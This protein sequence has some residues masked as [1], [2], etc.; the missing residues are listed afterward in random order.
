VSDRHARQLVLSGWTL[1][2]QARLAELKAVVPGVGPRSEVCALYLVGA[3]VGTLVSEPEVA[4]VCRRLDA[5]TRLEAIDSASERLQLG[6]V[7]IERADSGDPVAD[8]AAE[9]AALLEVV[10]R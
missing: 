2:F 8:G 6:E 3:G 1:E 5:R 9:A 7:E 10:L 4:A